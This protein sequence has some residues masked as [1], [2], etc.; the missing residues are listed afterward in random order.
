MFKVFSRFV[1]LVSIVIL[2]LCVP[3]IVN[4]Y[5]Q[6]NLLPK[7]PSIINPIGGESKDLKVST[8]GLKFPIGLSL[9]EFS[10]DILKE[11]GKKFVFSGDELALSLVPSSDILKGKVHLKISGSGILIHPTRADIA[12]FSENGVNYIQL[13]A[14]KFENSFTCDLSSLYE[15]GFSI[16]SLK[17]CY[18]SPNNNS[19]PINLIETY[20]EVLLSGEKRSLSLREIK[21]S[22]IK[23]SDNHLLELNSLFREPV[24]VA[25]KL[26]LQEYP[27]NGMLMLL[28][29]KYSEERSHDIENKNRYQGINVNLSYF[30]YVMARE[31]GSDGVGQMIA[32]YKASEGI[33]D[34]TFLSSAL[35]GKISYEKGVKEEEFLTPQFFNKFSYRA[36]NVDS[37]NKVTEVLNE[38]AVQN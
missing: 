23:L 17:S 30:Y 1:T 25:Q 7:L 28:I 19:K 2:L 10:M 4:Y 29:K 13:V 9:S 35:L 3:Q 20:Y 37:E 38:E 36:Y 24:D 32:T 15:L 8:F 26:F 12:Q 5:A 6:S 14:R 16:D 11:N 33:K 27:L 31:I 21:D 34:E 22:I 18:Q